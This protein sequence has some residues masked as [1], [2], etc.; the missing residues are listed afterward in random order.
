MTA[1]EK[2]TIEKM[3][4]NI[5]NLMSTFRDAVVVM[6][7]VVEAINKKVEEKHVPISL[8]MNILSAVQSSM[9]KT[10][11]EA[12]SGYNS[13]LTALVKSVV[14]SHSTELRKTISDSF[15]E[16]IRTEDFKRSIVSAFSHKVARSII[17]NNDGLYD[18]VSNELKQDATFK[19][20]MALA[21]ANVVEE[22]LT[23][24]EPK[25]EGE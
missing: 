5:A 12:L 6:K 21:V 8:E 3:N 19:A 2:K 17:S 25:N 23:G 4:E 14:D 11:R 13:P 1:D 24:K 15:E 10:I 20:K 22:C 7:T 9:D 18:K 16:V